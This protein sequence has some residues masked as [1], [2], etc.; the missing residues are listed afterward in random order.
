M[1]NIYETDIKN[2]LIEYIDMYYL[3]LSNL[4]NNILNLKDIEEENI[5]KNKIK[6]FKTLLTLII[7]NDK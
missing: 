4:F 5:E 7:L 1:A 2:T 6:I 3:E